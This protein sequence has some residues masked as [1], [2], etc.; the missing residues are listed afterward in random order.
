MAVAI[1]KVAGVQ[2]VLQVIGNGQ[3]KHLIHLT[4]FLH[5]VLPLLAS[6][7]QQLPLAPVGGNTVQDKEPRASQST[8]RKIVHSLL[9][10][11]GPLFVP[12][13]VLLTASIFFIRIHYKVYSVLA[14]LPL[15]MKTDYGMLVVQFRCLN[16]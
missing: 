2:E 9:T 11:C 6:L 16:I 4:P 1:T 8:E 7:F 14:L 12:N 10:P 13:R 5:P 15:P 3:K